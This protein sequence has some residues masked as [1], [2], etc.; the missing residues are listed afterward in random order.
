[1][2]GVGGYSSGPV[3]LSAS[4]LGIP[5]LILEQN[6]T[7]GFTNRLLLRRSMKAVVAF[8]SSL[9]YFQGK[10]ILLG[11]PVREEFYV[12]PPKARTET[13][14][15][16]VFGG[17]LGSHILNQT[18]TETLG[19]LA[20]EKTRLRIFH[21]TGP[22][23]LPGVKEA[24]A[25]SGFPEAEV[26]AFFFEMASYFEK[27]DLV[28]CRAGATTIA[29]LIAAGKASIL[30]PF[31][32]AADDH[33]AKNARELERV[34]GATVILESELSPRRLAEKILR[35]LHHP[36]ELTAV[37]SRLARLRVDRPAERI[38]DL[39]LALVAGKG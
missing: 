11:N 4:L 20:P 24:Y 15:L 2:V 21:Q 35:F 16:L 18:M 23:D 27:A 25:Q 7:P 19:L 36:E 6:V 3:V 37:E 17:S 30:V 32:R 29:E 9:P 31:A 13:L 34:G 8:E 26:A 38:A 1:V 28:I 33:Q 10:A 12:L 14:T 5:T 39:C 22:D